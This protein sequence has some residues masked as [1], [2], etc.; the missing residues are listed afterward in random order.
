[1]CKVWK[2]ENAMKRKKENEK[3]E[4]LIDI[5]EG[6]IERW[7]LLG[8]GEERV[9]VAVKQLW[10]KLLLNICIENLHRI[11]NF[12]WKLNSKCAKCR[13]TFRLVMPPISYT[14]HLILVLCNTPYNTSLSYL[15]IPLL[16][17]FFNFIFHQTLY[18]SSNTCGVFYTIKTCTT[19]PVSQPPELIFENPFE[20]T[21]W[22]SA[23]QQRK[24]TNVLAFEGDSR[25]P[26]KST[27]A[28]STSSEDAWSCY[29]AGMNMNNAKP[30]FYFLEQTNHLVRIYLFSVTSFSLEALLFFL[31]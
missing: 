7:Q 17:H 10:K 12:V 28:G 19:Y 21:K 2:A 8:Q 27:E 14:L 24:P 26:S 18:I 9:V 30:F 20:A 4:K 1:M 16:R 31:S 22:L 13:V 11:H 29:C 25:P 5:I 6:I 15:S 23:S 3:T